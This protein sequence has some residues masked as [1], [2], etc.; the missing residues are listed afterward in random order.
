MINENR[1]KVEQEEEWLKWA[2]EIPTLNFPEEFNVKIIP[3]ST[4]AI[5]RFAV[6]FENAH[7]SV[8]LDCYENLGYFGEP[9]WEIY[10]FKDG[11]VERYAMNN[12]E[13]LMN[14]IKESINGQLLRGSD[15]PGR[16]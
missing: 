15:F 5:V 11:D 8:Y 13:D 3:P 16:E 2:S 6:T 9:Y 1:I 10:P 14:G 4:G 12:T 7:V